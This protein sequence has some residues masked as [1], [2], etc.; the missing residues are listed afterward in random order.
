MKRGGVEIVG[1]AMN[2]TLPP[3]STARLPFDPTLLIPNTR[4]S[5]RRLLEGG[6]LT[7]VVTSPFD[8]LRASEF[9]F[10]RYLSD[11]GVP[12]TSI[13]YDLIPLLFS[14]FYL[15][16]ISFRDRYFA[17]LRLLERCDA[18]FCISEATRA[19]VVANTHAPEE[20]V[21]VIGGGVSG[22]FQLPTAIDG[23]RAEVV[24]R[25]PKINKPY[26]LCVAGYEH[27][28]NV[29]GLLAAWAL[30]A[31]ELR[32]QYQLVVTC[33][34]PLEGQLLWTS[35]A[36]VAG[37]R[38]RRARPHWARR[39]RDLASSLPGH[40]PL[41]LSFDLR[42]LRPTSRRGSGVRGA[43][44]HVRPGITSGD[45]RLATCMLFRRRAIDDRFGN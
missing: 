45:S 2:P 3:L 18:L 34:L 42:G 4:R 23:A 28:K 25:C 11:A 10:P 39:R 7:Y 32:G 38:A 9:M 43:R 31:S 17:Q 36:S 27:R 26:V 29:E 37:Y 41:R 8:F 19:D 35:L 14:D 15:R 6:P 13:V 12:T 21:H 33:S 30:L 16:D 22:F 40:D 1:A 24:G 20:R 44:D 5:L